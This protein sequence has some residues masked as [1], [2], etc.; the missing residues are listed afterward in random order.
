MS[1]VAAE[2]DPERGSVALRVHMKYRGPDCLLI[3]WAE[4]SLV[5]ADDRRLAVMALVDLGVVGHQQGAAPQP[6]DA[7]PVESETPTTAVT[8]VGEDIG[9]RLAGIAVNVFGPAILIA[10]VATSPVWIPIA[11]AMGKSRQAGEGAWRFGP[12]PPP[13][14]LVVCRGDTVAA[15]VSFAGHGD[16]TATRAATLELRINAERKW[17]ARVPIEPAAR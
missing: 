15:V 12:E 17:L 5:L 9:S 13:N 2:R 1:A 4:S 6:Q 7:M 10:A 8:S 14:D 11:A 16:A 3:R